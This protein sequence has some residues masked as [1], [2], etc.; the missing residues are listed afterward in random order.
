MIPVLTDLL[1]RYC[2]ESDFA[3]DVHNFPEMSSDAVPR[4]IYI[5]LAK[6]LDPAQEQIIRNE[7]EQVVPARFNPLY[8]KFRNGTLRRSGSW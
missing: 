2:G 1:R 5:T 8:L 4:V 7:L 3:V 6:Y